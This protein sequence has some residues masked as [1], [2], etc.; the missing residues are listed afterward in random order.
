MF[1]SFPRIL[2]RNLT[3]CGLSEVL[4]SSQF[5]HRNEPSNMSVYYLT[6]DLI[7]YYYIVEYGCNKRQMFGSHNY[8]G[9]VALK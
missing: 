7:Y 8:T 2:T 1:A 3:V 4:V 9:K 6:V 5:I